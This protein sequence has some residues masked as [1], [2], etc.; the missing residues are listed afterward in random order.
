M[1]SSSKARFMSRSM[2]FMLLPES[3]DTLT[4][5]MIITGLPRSL[6]CLKQ[7]ASTACGASSVKRNT[8]RSAVFAASKASLVSSSPSKAPIPGTSVTASPFHSYLLIS[9]VVRCAP[10]PIADPSPSVR[11]SISVDLPAMVRP[12]SVTENFSRSSFSAFK[13][14]VNEMRRESTDCCMSESCPSSASPRPM[15]SQGEALYSIAVSLILSS[16]D[17]SILSST[18]RSSAASSYPLFAAS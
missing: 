7:S 17:S 14:S 2:S 5:I 6:T 3:T 10:I 18:A 9:L 12:K 16:A 11:T 1:R 4:F 15:T 13:S 8:M